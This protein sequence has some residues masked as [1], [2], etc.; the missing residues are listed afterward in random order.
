VVLKTC[1]SE[2]WSQQWHHNYEGYLINRHSQMCLEAGTQG[3]LYTKL[4]I[5]NCARGQT[6]HQAWDYEDGRYKNQQYGNVLTNKCMVAARKLE[7]MS[8]RQNCSKAWH[9]GI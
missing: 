3:T 4:F 6:L 7:K 1:N 5:Y 8:H 9:D 2:A